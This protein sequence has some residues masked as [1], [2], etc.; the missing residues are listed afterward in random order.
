MDQATALVLQ[1]NEGKKITILV[2]YWAAHKDGITIKNLDGSHMDIS[3]NEYTLWGVQEIKFD[4][5][6]R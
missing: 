4:D 1:N 3:S 6:S 2:R 5:A